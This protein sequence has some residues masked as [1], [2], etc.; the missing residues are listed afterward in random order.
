MV[1]IKEFRK[2][3]AER[4]KKV[5]NESPLADVDMLLLSKGYTKNDLLL[6]DKIIDEKLSE[7]LEKSLREIEL[8]TPVQYVVGCCEFMSLPFAVTKDT[9][10]PRADT[11]ILVE[12]IISRLKNKPEPTIF[13]VGSGSGCIAVSLAYYLPESKIVSADIS[14]CALA[15]ARKNAD[16]N[17]V[18][19]RVSFVNHNIMKGFWDFEKCPDAIVSNPPYI[20]KE[21]ILKLDKKVRDFEPL[22]ALDGGIDGL[23]FYRLIAKT[24]PLEKGGILAFEVGI[25]QADKVAELMSPNFKNIELIK[26]LSGID[27]VVIGIKK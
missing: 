10:I 4:L 9:L 25:G 23:D 14:E 5:N 26:D 3:A 19:S 20:P 1:K 27:R 12:E 18:A 16:I 7:E 24:A 2:A 13:E 22:S 6:G 11:E 21:D 17:G 15:V 8:G